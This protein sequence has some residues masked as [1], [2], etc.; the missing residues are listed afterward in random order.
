MCIITVAIVMVVILIIVFSTHQQNKI[1]LAISI[2]RATRNIATMVTKRNG[3]VYLKCITNMAVKVLSIG[4]DCA[5]MVGCWSFTS[6]KHLRSYQD[7]YR[8][9]TVRTH[10]E[11]YSRSP[12]MSAEQAIRKRVKG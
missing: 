5:V 11:K 1:A 7:G 9:V 10:V 8:L 12:G 3:S 6:L 2:I 4:E